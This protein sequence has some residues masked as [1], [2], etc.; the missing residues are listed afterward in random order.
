MAGDPSDSGPTPAAPD[1]IL[2]GLQDEARIGRA[3]AKLSAEQARVVRLAF[4]SDKPHSRIADELSVPLGTVKSRLR[5]AMGRLR[6][7][8]GEAA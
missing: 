7:L 3:I 6:T 2:M 5:L 4:F 8:L 1:T